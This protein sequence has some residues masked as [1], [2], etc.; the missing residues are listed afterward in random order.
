MP[1]HP[2]VAFH[3]FLDELVAQRAGTQIQHG[4]AGDGFPGAVM[5]ASAPIERYIP[6]VQQLPTYM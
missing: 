4:R 3:I 5:V 1:F 6:G 2:R